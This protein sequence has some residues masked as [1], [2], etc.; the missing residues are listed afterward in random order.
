VLDVDFGHADPQLVIPYG[1][2]IRIDG[3]TH[4]ITVRY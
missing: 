4:H 2:Q 1:G 3:T